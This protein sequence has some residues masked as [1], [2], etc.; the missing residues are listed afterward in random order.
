MGGWEFSQWQGDVTGSAN[1]QSVV[2]SAH[3]NVVAQFTRLVT[4]DTDEAA[5][6]PGRLALSQNWPN[7]FNPTTTLRYSVPRRD[8]VLL[9][10]YDVRGRLVVTLVDALHN[11]GVYKQIWDGRNNT[12]LRVPSGIYTAR[13]RLR[14]AAALQSGPRVKMVL[15]H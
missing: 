14:S 1:P 3:M 10:V 11:P 15:I 12:G 5:V 4:S 6:V 9:R 8:H 13:L 7:P 2:V